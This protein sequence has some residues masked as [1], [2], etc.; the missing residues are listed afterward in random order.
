M[1]GRPL[2]VEFRLPPIGTSPAPKPPPGAKAER[3][4]LERAA[5]RARRLALAHHLDWLLQSGRASDLAAISEQTGVT[6]ARI[7]QVYSLIHLAPDLQ[8]KVLCLP[9]SGSPIPLGALRA[10]ASRLDWAQ[11]R[12]CFPHES[13]RK[14]VEARRG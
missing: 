10:A 9:Q 13:S 11:Q 8:I 3:L 7:T 1:K 2:T 12:R 4:R 5:R 6:R 14:A